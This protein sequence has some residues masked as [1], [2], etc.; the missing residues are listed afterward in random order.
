MSDQRKAASVGGSRERERHSVAAPGRIG[1]D[2][3]DPTMVLA[4][5]LSIEETKCLLVSLQERGFLGQVSA[6]PWMRQ[7]KN[8]VLVVM[9]C[10]Q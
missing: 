4:P 1:A 7:K 3:W 8:L 2:L 9:P 10:P 6:Q 5:D